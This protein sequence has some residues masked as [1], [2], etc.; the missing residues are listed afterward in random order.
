MVTLIDDVHIAQ[1][2]AGHAPGG[3]ELAGTASFTAP[4]GQKA[5]AG[6]ELLNAII[7]FIGHIRIPDEVHGH[8][9][10]EEKGPVETSIPTPLQQRGSIALELLNAGVVG[11]GHVNIAVLIGGHTPGSVE[12]IHVSPTPGK[13][14]LTP[15]LHGIAVGVEALHAIVSGIGDVHLPV[16]IRGQSARIIEAAFCAAGF[17]A[18]ATEKF[19]VFVE[20]LDGV[21]I[22]IGHVDIAV[23]VYRNTSRRTELAVLHALLP[24]DLGNEVGSRDR[25][26]FL[27]FGTLP[28]L[29]HHGHDIVVARSVCQIVMHEGRLRTFNTCP[30][31]LGHADDGFEIFRAGDGASEFGEFNLH[32]LGGHEIQVVIHGLRHSVPGYH[33]PAISGFG[34]HSR[35]CRRQIFLL[36]NGVP[37]APFALT[38]L[39]REIPPVKPKHFVE[40][41]SL[42]H[43]VPRGT[44]L[45][46]IG[47]CFN[48]LDRAV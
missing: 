23:L 13:P 22:G 1:G 48:N 34:G 41:P 2:I 31:F 44:R 20:F 16:R 6:I 29:S 8:T 7:P 4:L 33:H 14:E 47:G 43:G 28:L 3:F 45:V 30:L 5:S 25:H 9:A 10:R 24:D 18:P 39:R 19:S 46:K 37:G 38:P 11:I 26:D 12:L 40:Q 17:A 15:G 36:R 42:D 35:R 21:I 32:A 27:G